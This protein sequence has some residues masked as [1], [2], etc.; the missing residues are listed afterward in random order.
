MRRIPQS[1]GHAAPDSNASEALENRYDGMVVETD[2]L[3]V[4]DYLWILYRHR[5]MIVAIMVA[6]FLGSAWYN[7]RAMT[8]YEAW[9][10]LQIEADPNVLGLDRPL[11]EQRDWM[12]E[13]LP[14]QLAVL[15]SRE[16]ANL[17]REE[18]R[19]FEKERQVPTA[20]EIVEARSISDVRNTRLVNIGFRSTDPV[21]AAEV[22]N[23]LG[24][25][26][27]KWIFEFKAK[28]AGDASDWLVKQVEQQRQVVQA[29]EAALQRYREQHG[30]DALRTLPTIS[31]SSIGGH[32]VVLQKLAELQA[33]VT[34]ARAQTIEKQAQYEQLSSIQASKEAPDTLP[35]IA[36]NFYILS[37]KGEVTTLQRQLAQAS[38]K[39][40]E[41]HPELIRL[42]EA[43]ANAERKLQTEMSKVTAGVRNDYETARARERAMAAALERQKGEVQEL[44]AKAVE[45]TA[46]EGEAR[47]NRELLDNLVQRSRQIELA[48]DLPT[49]SARLLDA[50]Q[51]PAVPI[52]P[53]KQRNLTLGLVCSG[54]LAFGLVFLREIFNTRMT[55]PDD[56]TRHLRIPLLGVAPKV[57]SRNGQGSLLLSEGAPPQFT[58]LLHSVRTSLV[59]APELATAHTL[60]VTSSQPGEGKTVAAANLAVS[61]ARLNHRVLLIDADLRKPRLHEVFGFEQ[62][63]GLTDVL[64]GKA[65]HNAIRTTKVP[66]LWLL[67]SGLPSRHAAD[68]LGSERF[69]QLIECFRE[70]FDWIV[71]DSP[72]VLPV[73][74]ACLITR[75][76]SGVLFVVGSG[77]TSRDVGRAA[78]ERLD[79]VGA[80]LVGALLNRAEVNKPGYSYLP[81]YH[82]DYDYYPQQERSWVPGL[83]ETSSSADS[84]AAAP[85]TQGGS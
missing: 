3:Q 49:A 52:R 31:N 11:V 51:V 62:Q 47:A 75:V 85:R 74:D 50:A 19:V 28:T 54:V 20:G 78:V 1:H 57:K 22:A 70:Q 66:R 59:F 63:P 5:W 15:E 16:L 41:R 46:L 55:S 48:R 42:Q 53:R 25:A 35:A 72:P 39:L 23:A 76:A 69:T 24:R 38:D 17:A 68:L 67:P 73:T 21:M 60:L 13:F 8:I 6:G 27:V 10:T 37:L 64:K 45:Y 18:L 30:A 61:L 71:L 44:N 4:R 40:G 7:S 33:A 9:A 83:P 65:T 29:S 2:S 32:N 84:A 34:T 79:A 36:S 81:Y 12:R 77:Q 56:V 26:Y 14:T 82:R 58:E 43:V 80:N